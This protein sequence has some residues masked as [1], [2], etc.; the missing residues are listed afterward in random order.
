MEA[1]GK[2]H[3][4]RASDERA[5]FILSP[6]ASRCF[7]FSLVMHAKNRVI[8][9]ADVNTANRHCLTILWNYLCGI[10]KA[11]KLGIYL[12]TKRNS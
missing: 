7:F 11:N 10:C 6:K 4:E 1:A 8:E 9:P 2:R 12:V 5:F 3:A